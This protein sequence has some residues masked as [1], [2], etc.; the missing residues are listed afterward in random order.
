MNLQKGAVSLHPLAIFWIGV[1]TGALIVGLAF[2]YRT[3]SAVDYES[4]IL[5][6]QYS[7]PT[8]QQSL[9]IAPSIS[10]SPT[11]SLSIGTPD[12]N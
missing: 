8:Y 2:F 6:Y 7:T 1:L 11:G 9:G 3:L 5:R 4:A 10:T 12:G